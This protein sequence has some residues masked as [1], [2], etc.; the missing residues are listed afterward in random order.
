MCAEVHVCG[1]IYID[2]YIMKHSTNT[3]TLQG[4]RYHNIDVQILFFLLS[5]SSNRPF[6]WPRVLDGRSASGADDR[7]DSETIS[8]ELGELR[9]TLNIQAKSYKL[10]TNVDIMVLRLLDSGN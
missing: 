8:T 4:Y 10:K 3:A 6:G 1:Y 7:F 5:T 2:I 9:V